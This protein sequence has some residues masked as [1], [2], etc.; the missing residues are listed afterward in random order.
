MLKNINR[1]S[2]LEQNLYK[3]IAI[4]VQKFLCDPRISFVFTISEVKLSSD[5]SYAK[6]FVTSLE[7][8]NKKKN[9]LLIYVLQNASGFIRYHLGKK[10]YL[11]I[12]PKLYFI[13]DYSFITGISI[14]KILKKNYEINHY[15]NL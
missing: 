7:Y 3:E 11:R 14:S 1:V 6:I 15:T 4:I 9:D 5:L 10:I 13:Y 8:K 12:I 2:R